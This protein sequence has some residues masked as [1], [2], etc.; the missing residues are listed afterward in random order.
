VNP[1]RARRAAN[2]NAPCSTCSRRTRA[3]APSKPQQDSI[4][5]LQS[6]REA[7]EYG[8]NRSDLDQPEGTSSAGGRPRLTAYPT[9]FPFLPF[10]LTPLPAPCPS[11]PPAFL[12]VCPQPVRRLGRHLHP[13]W[14]RAHSL[15]RQESTTDCQQ[16]VAQMPVIWI[17]MT[18]ASRSTCTSILRVVRSP[19]FWRSSTPSSTSNRKV[20]TICVVWRPSMG[21]FLLAAGTKGKR[22]P[23]PRRNQ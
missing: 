11:A 2:N 8:L 18:A 1:I 17:P 14:C 3:A 5:D 21:A 13:A 16:L 9:A 4:G 22:W 19:P 23:C 6:R 12:T 10:H 7:L 15:S 20:V